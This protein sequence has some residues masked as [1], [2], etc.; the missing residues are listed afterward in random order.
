M[1][2]A[3][4]RTVVTGV[5]WMGIGVGSIETALN[6]MLSSCKDEII[7]TAYSLTR[8][9]SVIL[10]EITRLTE[11]GRRVTLI[12][13]KLKEQADN[14]TTQLLLKLANKYENFL[15]YDF[16][17]DTEA[18]MHAKVI[19]VDRKIALIGS[20]NLSSRGLNFNHELGVV[21]EG[22]AVS[23]ISIA[24]DKLITSQ[25]LIGPIRNV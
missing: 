4:V 7:L 16:N 15:L 25:H 23:E 13:N 12:V 17:P 9:A 11:I 8:G 6:E 14:Q 2:N 18:D 20:S 21:I 22:E 19:I 3:K 1:K 5:H 10:S 24:I